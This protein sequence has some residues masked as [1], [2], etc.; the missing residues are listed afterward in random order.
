MWLIKHLPTDEALGV[1]V[2]DWGEGKR[3]MMKGRTRS[4]RSNR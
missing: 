4:T 2:G 3:M 1:C